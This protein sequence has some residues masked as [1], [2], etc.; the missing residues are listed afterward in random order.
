MCLCQCKQLSYLFRFQSHRRVT[1]HIFITFQC[2][3]DI[4]CPVFQTGSDINDIQS[5]QKLSVICTIRVK[6]VS[7]T[8]F[9][10]NKNV[11]G[12]HTFYMQ[13]ADVL[14]LHHHFVVLCIIRNNAHAVDHT[15]TSEL[16]TGNIFGTFQINDL[17]VILQIIKFATPIRTD[18]QKIDI[19]FCN[20]I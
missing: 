4:I 8:E 16:G 14:G 11:L 12:I 1:D 2:L 3:S 7:V 15:L 10:R 17:T 20:V 5:F 18:Y 9:S 19:V 13:S 6:F